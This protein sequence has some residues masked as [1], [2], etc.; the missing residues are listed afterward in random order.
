MRNEYLAAF[1]TEGNGVNDLPP[2]IPAFER[3]MFEHAFETF[4][5]N[6]DG[7]LDATEQAALLEYLRGLNGKH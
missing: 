5:R 6:H 1:I 4:D 2:G 7:K 3:R